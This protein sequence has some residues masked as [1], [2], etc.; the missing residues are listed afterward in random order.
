MFLQFLNQSH[1][2]PLQI[3]VLLLQSS[4][5]LLQRL[6][7]LH[8]S[9]VIILQ[10]RNS[11]VIPCLHHL[12]KHVMDIAT[13]RDCFLLHFGEQGRDEN[14]SAGS[15]IRTNRIDLQTVIWF[16]RSKRDWAVFYFLKY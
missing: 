6:Y 15:S 12:P 13:V 2:L 4:I 10:T 16:V 3:L 11:R 9:R 5:S 1:I 8:Q 7:L 14:K